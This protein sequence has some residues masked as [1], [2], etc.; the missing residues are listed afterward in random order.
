MM[1]PL[2]VAVLALLLPSGVY[3]QALGSYRPQ[4]DTIAYES[5]NTY[6]MFFVRGADTLGEPVTTRTR[7]RQHIAARGTELVVWVGLQSLDGQPFSFDDTYTITPGGRVTAVGTKPVTEAPNARV[8]LLPRFPDPTATLA[9][10][11]SWRDTVAVRHSLP[12]GDTYYSV[13]RQFRVQ[14]LIDT[15]GTRVAHIVATGTMRLRQGGWQDSSAGTVWWQEV[16]GPVADTVWFDTRGGA[17]IGDVTVMRLM[18]TGGAG[19]KSGGAT[20]PS[21]LYSLVRRQRSRS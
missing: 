10:G 3:G 11:L 15:L 13:Q 14:R 20:M 7:E 8:D 9:V 18:G 4:R 12:Y 6:L 2:R 5:L 21:G 19:P 16:A 17:L 1:F